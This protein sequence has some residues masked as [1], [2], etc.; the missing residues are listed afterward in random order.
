MRPLAAAAAL[1]VLALLG[2]TTAPALGAY[3]AKIANTANSVGSAPYFLC[4]DALAQDK[5][6]ALFQWPLSDT[7][8]ATAAADISGKG[9][10]GTYQ[11]TRAVDTAAPLACPRDGG[12]AWSLDGT[13]SYADLATQQTNPTTFTIEIWFRTTTPTGRLIGFGSSATGGSG[14]F[15]RHLYVNKS[16]GVTFGVYNGAVRTI[17]SPATTYANGAWHYAA[18]TL[19]SGGIVLYVDGVKVASDTTVTTAQNYNG[20][21]RVGYDSLSGWTNVGTSNYFKGSLR[22]AAVYTT[23]LTATQIGNHF[24]AGSGT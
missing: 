3:T 8:A 11:G 24:G 9:A 20:Y 4:S 10:T 6:N 16:G 7:A 15:D 12:R 2:L 17:S 18:A 1:A 23:A 13:S 5:A 19:S 21:W 22:Y 14:S